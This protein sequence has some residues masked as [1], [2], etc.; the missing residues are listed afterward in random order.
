MDHEKNT[1]LL[2]KRVA[3]LIKPHKIASISTISFIIIAVVTFLFVSSLVVHTLFPQYE[4]VK[5]YTVIGVCTDETTINSTVFLPISCASLEHTSTI[6]CISRS[7]SHYVAPAIASNDQKTLCPTLI[8][9]TDSTG[10]KNAALA[11][12][13]V[14]EAVLR[15]MI[16]VVVILGYG[17]LLT[18][19]FVLSRHHT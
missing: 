5:K 14:D 3:R 11:I 6:G 18:T 16:S 13:P 4:I 19:A 9:K 12:L 2:N 17:A 8:S 10:L 7:V 1:S 15:S